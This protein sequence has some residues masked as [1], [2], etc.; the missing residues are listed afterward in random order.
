STNKRNGKGSNKGLFNN[1]FNTTKGKN[2]LVEH[3]SFSNTKDNGTQQVSSAN[4]FSSF[5]KAIGGEMDGERFVG[6]KST[7]R[8]PSNAEPADR[9]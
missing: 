9:N 6:T 8:T 4:I 7:S 3:T 5:S 1:N 2:I